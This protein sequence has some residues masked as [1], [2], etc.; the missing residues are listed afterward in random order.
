MPLVV[1]QLSAQ[2]RRRGNR[3]PGRRGDQ[4]GPHPLE[5]RPH[6]DRHVLLLDLHDTGE[7]GGEGLHGLDLADQAPARATRHPGVDDDPV[8]AELDDR[9][10]GGGEP[11]HLLGGEGLSVQGEL[12]LEGEHRIGSEQP[13][14]QRVV[15]LARRQDGAGGELATETARPE[16]RYAARLQR[17]DAVLQQAGELITIE[18][19][20]IGDPGLEQALQHRPGVGRGPQRDRGVGPRPVSEAVARVRT[21]LG[22]QQGRVC[23][24]GSVSFVVN[25]EDQPAG[26]VDQLLLVGLDPQRQRD[27]VWPVILASGS[28]A[29]R[30]TGAGA[31]RSS[32]WWRARP[33]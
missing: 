32:P 4:V 18:R 17:R 14:H 24:M 28:G 26:P 29:A 19:D 1:A 11:V 21:G 6:D 20:R 2:A 30:P 5:G 12:P 33:S 31:P 27:Q 13:G 22:P 16:H 10:R 3:V 9:R 23:D 7:S 25:L 15:V 8:V